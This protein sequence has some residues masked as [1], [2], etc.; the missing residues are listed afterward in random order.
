MNHAASKSAPTRTALRRLAKAAPLAAL[1]LG[2]APAAAERIFFDDF[3]G[4]AGG[5]TAT[6]QTSLSNWTIDGYVDVIGTGNTLGYTVGSTVIDLGGGLT[7]G[8][9]KSKSTFRYDAGQVVTISWDMAGNQ[10]RPLGEDVPYLQFYFEQT[11]PE[12]YQEVYYLDGT[13]FFDFA[14]FYP[15]TEGENT[16]RIFD[17][18]FAYGYGLFGDYP[19]TRQSI[20]FRPVIAGAFQ[21]ELGTYSGGGYGPLI[22]NFAVDV[23]DFAA[24]VPEPAT[25]A[26]LIAGFGAVGLRARRRRAATVAA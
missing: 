7:G 23:T 11:N 12:S 6:F 21:F 14:D 24:P 2:A 4:E 15:Y 22:D 5:G 10:I 17:Q 18:Y 3:N 16:V 9:M 19:T 20:S 13:A 25:W 8:F 1:M 26:M